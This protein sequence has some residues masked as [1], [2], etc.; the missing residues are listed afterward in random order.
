MNVL[1]TSIPGLLEIELAVFEDSRG[2]FAET[3]RFETYKAAGITGDFVQDNVSVSVRGVL[4]GLHY[5]IEHPQGHLVTVVSG[6]IFDVGV[7]LRASSPTFGN[8]FGVELSESRLSQVYLPPGVAHGF[9]TMSDR[10][11][12]LYKCTDY[13]HPGDEAGLHWAD[14]DVAIDWPTDSPQVVERDQT[15]PCLKDIEPSRLPRATV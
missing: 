6:R 2:F 14:S 7:D 4:R 3:W 1:T 9:Y 10:A 13:Y 5:Q 8:W 15:L 12:I 11:E